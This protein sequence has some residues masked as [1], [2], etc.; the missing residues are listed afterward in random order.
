MQE[1]LVIHGRVSWHPRQSEQSICVCSR[2]SFVYALIC[3]HTCKSY[4]Y[5]GRNHLSY[6]TPSHPYLNHFA[7]T[8][9]PNRIS[10]IPLHPNRIPTA[11]QSHP[12]RTPI[13]SPNH[14]FRP[15][16]PS[17]I[18]IVVVVVAATPTAP[19]VLAESTA[20]EVRKRAALDGRRRGLVPEG[21]VAPGAV[22]V[23]LFFEG[24]VGSASA[25]AHER[26]SER[27]SE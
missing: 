8:S 17:L 25:C 23:V 16:P 4:K 12:D 14:T 3:L 9:H 26:T 18:V 15:R 22:E 24:C 10:S 27:A 21:Q 19:L 11:S 2:V 7:I 1:R 20:K 5:K 6:P 13:A